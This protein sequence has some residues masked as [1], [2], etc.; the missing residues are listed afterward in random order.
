MS[1]LK[2]SIHRF[3]PEKKI[4]LNGDGF[5][6]ANGETQIGFDA[7]ASRIFLSRKTETEGR[8]V[9]VTEE[10]SYFSVKDFSVC[11][12]MFNGE[13]E[14]IFGQHITTPN[15]V[16]LLNLTQAS[17][18]NIGKKLVKKLRDEY[19]NVDYI[20]VKSNKDMS[21]LLSLVIDDIKHKNI[22]VLSLE[23][24]F[25]SLNEKMVFTSQGEYV[26]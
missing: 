23:D 22:L 16:T 4:I 19:S 2:T 9:A 17:P 26:L 14:P 13:G 1:L 8:N 6:I 15:G 25:E 7:E 5:V 3:D 20:I 11:G 18:A 21:A 12:F 10:D 24:G